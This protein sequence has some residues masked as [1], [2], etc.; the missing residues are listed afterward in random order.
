MKIGK[1]TKRKLRASVIGANRHLQKAIEKSLYSL[2]RCTHYSEP[3]QI[4][5]ALNSDLLLYSL[6]KPYFSSLQ[7][8]IDC[9][10]KNP[11]LPVILMANGLDANHAV[12]LI[13]CG[14]S[15][16][17][18]LPIDN[19]TLRRKVERL[20]L[21]IRRPAIDTWTMLPFVE[22][23]KSENRLAKESNRRH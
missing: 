6:H 14:V 7:G 4:H 5:S 3:D 1:Q 2:A 18:D 13:K 15:D 23:Q 12:E 21:N 19:L 10:T 9:L 17:I 22:Y 11:R 20:L 8:L 16:F